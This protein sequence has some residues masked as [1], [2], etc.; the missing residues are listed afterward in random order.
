M[1]I[2]KTSTLSAGPGRVPTY[3]QPLIYDVVNTPGT[4]REAATL[5]R[6]ARV[7]MRAL[8]KAST[9]ASGH[10]RTPIIWLEP[11]TGSGRFLRV[12]GQRGEACIGIDLE[13][14]MIRFAKA[15]IRRLAIAKH[16][17]A[18]PG[19]MCD[20]TAP[21]VRRAIGRHLRALGD[22]A[23]VVAFCP[24]NSIRHLPSDG[25]MHEHLSTMAELLAPSPLRR[26]SRA[27][28]SG[29]AQGLYIVGIGLFG[30]GEEHIVE[31]VLEG[32]SRGHHAREVIEFI[33]PPLSARGAQSRI[34]KAYKHVSVR[35]LRRDR[36]RRAEHEFIS[37]YHLRTF[38]L[39]QWRDQLKRAGLRELLVVNDAGEPMDR[40][41]LH[42]AH[43]VLT[44]V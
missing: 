40:D 26:G 3:A 6:I 25:A 19:D 7:G 38:T 12:L 20:M 22:H 11:G 10:A 33:P 41:R 44:P 30:P 23:R 15:D 5:R 8:G 17:V 14:A 9:D 36:G 1:P 24:H 42:Y 31:S 28:G 18:L 43:R 32:R 27:R 21:P 4:A 16:A 35:E 13:P 34:E 2:T 37:A 39:D 29:L